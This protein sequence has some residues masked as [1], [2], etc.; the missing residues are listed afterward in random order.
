MSTIVKVIALGGVGEIGKNCYVVEQGDDLVV[1][2]VGLSF[3]NEEM[4]GVDIVI[5]DFTYLVKNRER[6]RGIFLTH[7]HEDHVGSLPY[8]L[9]KLHAPIFATEFTHALIKQK[10]EEKT[11]AKRLRL[12]TIKPG[13]S[14]RVGSLEVEAVRVTH[15]IPETCAMA[16]KTVHGVIL[17]TSDFKFDFTPIDNKLTNVARLGEL[18][19]EGVLCLLSDTTNVD[20]PG[21]GPSERSVVHGLR[22]VFESA[23]G[24]ILL[25]TFASNIHRLQQT[26]D[27]AHEFGR[28]VSVV[29][30]RMEQNVETCARL[31]YLKIPK[32]TRGTLDDAKNLPDDKV[33][34]LT[35]GSQ[36]EPMSALVQMSREEYG[37]LSVRKGDTLIYSARTIPGNEAGVWRTINRLFR[38]G[39]D[40]VYDQGG[41][42]PVHVSG[43]GYQEEL[44]MMMNLTRPFYIAPV[45]GEPRHFHKY[46]QIAAD[47]GIPDHRMFNLEDGVTLCFDETKAWL[48]DKVEFGRVLVDNSGT[49]GVTEEVLRDRFNLSKDGVLSVTVVIDTELSELVGDPMV[50]GKGMN[51]AETTFTT[52]ADAVRDLV[53]HMKPAELK[54]VDFVRHQVGDF[55]KK[56]VYKKVQLRPLIIPNVVEI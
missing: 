28:T 46:F 14:T 12:E 32:D 24:R 50:Q 23:K 27:L 18:G 35:T 55:V 31:G 7:A 2:D 22:K 51:T 10:L 5:P 56:F 21:W 29:G 6:I 48:G 1:I 16:I 41:G 38:L 39:V 3:P 54:D 26:F 47:M 37:R 9:Q 15:S 8:L 11:D 30:R 25:T 19:N 4:F 52:V 45:H 42:S 34:V 17:F 33:V 53:I 40:V 44:K 49:S 13:D 43:H 36:G 20:R